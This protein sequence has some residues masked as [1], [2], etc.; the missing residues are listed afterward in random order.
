MKNI[1]L[2]TGIYPD[3]LAILQAAGHNLIGPMPNDTP[4]RRA[5]FA[6]AHAI[7]IASAWQIDDAQL[8]QAPMLQVIG[9]PGIG[10]DNVDLDA[11]TR[12]GVC[13]VHTPDAPTQSTAEHAFTLLIGLAKNIVTVD[14][15]FRARGWDS[16]NE[17][18]VGVELKGKT[19][20]LVGLGRIGGTV[21][22]MAQGF[23]MRVIVFDPY[24]D[25]ARAQ[26]VGVTRVASLDAVLQAA[27]FVSLHSALTAQTRH[28][29]G[30][31]QL[32]MM[33][34][35]AFLINCSRGPVI[36]EVALLDALRSKRIAGA[37][38]DVFDVEPTPD[39]NPLLKLDNVI[40]SPHIASR[41]YE[42]VYMMATGIAE[43]VNSVLRGERPRWLPNKEVWE[44]RRR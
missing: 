21:A 3:G 40:V 29:I 15:S 11:C 24:I 28:M 33:K 31:A 39:D 4:E 5:A 38:L 22:K 43:E 18:G 42:G 30:A 34:P 14:Q 26:A 12:H 10:L 9:R 1:L 23:D 7:V 25:D 17:Y 20:G 13:V 2:D 44:R 27:D 19:L 37:G 8:A 36:D 6:T 41:T 16:R 35:T 32:E